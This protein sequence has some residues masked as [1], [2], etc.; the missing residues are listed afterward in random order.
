MMLA[1]EGSVAAGAACDPCRESLGESSQMRLLAEL[2]IPGRPQNGLM[3]S[4]A[5]RKE[6]VI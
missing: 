2:V 3:P 6:Q 1:M 5:D 4:G